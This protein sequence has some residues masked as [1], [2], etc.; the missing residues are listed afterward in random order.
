MT[1]P[2]SD[3]FER[4]FGEDYDDYLND[5]VGQVAPLLAA[6]QAMNA[7]TRTRTTSRLAVLVVA[8]TVVAAA[9]FSVWST[10]FLASN[11]A[12]SSAPTATPSASTSQ[13]TATPSSGTL[14]PVNGWSEQVLDESASGIEI[15]GWAADGSKF[16]VIGGGQ[17]TSDT[18]QVFSRDGVLLRQFPGQMAVWTD[19]DHLAV[20]VPAGPNQVSRVWIRGATSSDDR[21]L[22]V[23]DTPDLVSLGGVVTLWGHAGT[24][25]DPGSA[26]FRVLRSGQLSDPL[27]G[28]PVGGSPDGSHLAYVTEVH[29]GGTASFGSLQMLDVATMRS[30]NLGVETFATGGTAYLN[31]DGSTLLVSDC[32]SSPE[33]S[34]HVVLMDS[35]S[36]S[37]VADWP[38]QAQVSGIWVDRSRVLIE[39]G[40]QLYNWSIGSPPSLFP[41]QPSTAETLQGVDAAAGRLVLFVVDGPAVPSTI[42]GSS[43]LVVSVGSYYSDALTG[44]TLAPDGVQIAFLHG[45]PT[46][47]GSQLVLGTW[48]PGT[49]PSPIPQ[50]TP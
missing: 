6:R 15:V 16:A 24:G 38:S 42:A 4:R 47:L 44:G 14:Q 21:L 34:C 23:G 40:D 43:A 5:G 28:V 20:S 30:R 18:V 22:P 35:Q 31:E 19:S 7:G 9:V 33:G 48:L 25:A 17:V 10:R 11:E 45:T 8:A 50:R 41:W 13:P 32:P 3:D 36:G 27:V 29:G 26:I 39:T 2:R 1:E 49:A 37:V 12:A 46:R